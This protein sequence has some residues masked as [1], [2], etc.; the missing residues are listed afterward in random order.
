M[1]Q[2]SLDSFSRGRLS[3]LGSENDPLPKRFI[4]HRFS[5]H[6]LLSIA[7]I[8]SSRCA[9]RLQD[10]VHCRTAAP[11][12]GVSIP[13]T[14]PF[15]TYLPLVASAPCWRQHPAGPCHKCHRGPPAARQTATTTRSRIVFVSCSYPLRRAKFT[16]AYISR[17][18]SS[19]WSIDVPPSVPRA[20][21]S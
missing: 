10:P 20:R 6:I 19:G 9:C 4:Y 1:S 18:E 11:R 12:L 15:D 13:A 5:Q 8:I 2:F 3:C 16:P 7:C 21:P 17:R 14:D